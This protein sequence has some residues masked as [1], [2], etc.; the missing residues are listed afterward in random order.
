MEENLMCLLLVPSFEGNRIM[1]LP[2]SQLLCRRIIKEGMKVLCGQ[3][4]NNCKNH[5]FGSRECAIKEELLKAFNE[6]KNA[7]VITEDNP[8]KPIGKVAEREVAA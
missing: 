4:C 5:I 3:E 1:L 6:E 2:G 8:V 7:S